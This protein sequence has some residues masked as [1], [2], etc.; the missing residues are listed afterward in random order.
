MHVYLSTAE[1]ILR[2][3][4]P[5]SN[6]TSYNIAKQNNSDRSSLLLYTSYET[7]HPIT[8][9]QDA[10]DYNAYMDFVLLLIL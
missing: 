1:P 6:F 9:N 5:H 7:L 2:P 3:R 4:L 10:L 8:V